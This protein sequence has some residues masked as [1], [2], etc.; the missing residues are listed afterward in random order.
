MVLVEDAGRDRAS[1]A[2]RIGIDPTLAWGFA[3][4]LLFMIGDGVEQGW[5]PLYL[6]SIGVAQDQQVAWIF[7]LYG[8][9]AA[10]AAWLSGALSDLF[11]PRKVMWAGLIIWAV[12][13][14][15]LLLVGV[16]AKSYSQIMLFYTLRGFGYPL[17]AFGF[18]IWITTVTPPRRLGTSVGWFW[19][20]FTGGLLFLGPLFASEVKPRVGAEATLWWSLALVVAGGLIALLGVREPTGGRRLAPEGENPLRTLFQSLSIAWREPKTL[21]G[22]LVRTINTA[23]QNGFLVF[24]P[25]YFTKTV[26]FSENQWLRLLS[27]MFLSNI[28]WNLLF[29]I[30]GDRFGWR[31]TVAY[32]GGV[33]SAIT[34]LLLYY[35]PHLLGANFPLVALACIFYGA[36]LAGYVPLSALMPSLA[37]DHKAASMSL[38][39]LGAGASQWAGPAIVGLFLVPLGVAG[40]MWIFAVLYLLSAAMTLFLTL[41]PEVVRVAQEQ[42]S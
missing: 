35:T 39:N 4:L 12:F 40:V 34:T 16:P 3:G 28:I 31:R 23:P 29:G 42:E 33:G 6:T 41:P 24:F 8:I 30:I 15:A 1:I 7:F 20:S 21:V 19:F 36:T 14:A 18:L 13:E 5:L 9:T 10:A 22:C 17:F 32:C 38:L 2:D 11:G 26:G 25:A 27:L 37:P